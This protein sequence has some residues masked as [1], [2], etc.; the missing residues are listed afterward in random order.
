VALRLTRAAELV[1]WRSARRA[2]TGRGAARIQSAR[3][4]PARNQGDTRVVRAFPKRQS[5]L[6]LAAVRL[7]H[8]VGGRLTT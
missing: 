1:A 3:V 6:N 8:V 5:A 7:R 2:S 4:I